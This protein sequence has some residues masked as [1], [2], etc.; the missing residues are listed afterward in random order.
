MSELLDAEAM[1]NAAKAVFAKANEGNLKPETIESL[2]PSQHYP[3]W[4]GL[5]EAAVRA[6]L[7]AAPSPSPAPGVVEALRK[8]RQLV[9]IAT[10]WNLDE[11]EIV[12]EMVRTY[13]LGAE[14][15]TALASLSQPAK[16]ERDGGGE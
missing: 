16:G 1:K 14:F 5:A 13:S 9:D 4:D 7:S 15:D 2:W 3:H 11:V 8:A 6:Y 10:D 12:G